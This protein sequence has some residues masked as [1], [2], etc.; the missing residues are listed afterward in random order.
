MEQ[1]QL[2]VEVNKLKEALTFPEP[3]A[4]PFLIVISGLPG[5]GKSYLALELAERLPCTVVES[6]AMRKVLFP[7][8]CYS[9]GESQHLF[10]VLHLL[11]EELLSRGIPVILDA[12]NLVE[13]HREHLYRI[14]DRLGLKLI[15]VKVEAQAEV[16][17]QRLQ[18]RAQ[19]IDAG[20]KSDADW[21]VYQR[22]KP[23]AEQIRRQHFV[24]DTTRDIAPVITKI[25][26]ELKR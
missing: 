9:A 1:G 14:A 19:V 8:P 5:T 18:R 2:S 16:V 17:Q 6:D 3:R 10:Q 26:R 21:A 4:R 22:M 24:V 11:I 20:N 12:T 25:I 15:I 7:H 23:K 13:H